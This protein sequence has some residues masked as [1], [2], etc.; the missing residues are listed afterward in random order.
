MQEI[1]FLGKGW[2][3]PIRVGPGGAIQTADEETKVAQALEIILR[4]A[5]GERVMLPK[6][7]CGLQNL[8]FAPLNRETLA[9]VAEQ[10]KEAL[11]DYEPRIELESVSVDV[12]PTEES[13]LLIGIGY[14]VRA[15]NT[16]T[17]LVYPFYLDE[18]GEA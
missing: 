16:R 4:T 15:T 6:F 3:F 5:P 14:R 10:V 7:G 11:R 12:D 1:K 18:G 8:V 9:R 2:A 13:K 17:N